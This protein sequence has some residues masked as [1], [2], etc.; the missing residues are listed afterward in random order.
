[1]DKSR[2]PRTLAK[3]D[4]YIKRVNKFI[5]TVNPATLQTHGERLGLTPQEITR[6]GDFLAQWFTGNP[7][8]RGIYEIHTNPNTKTKNSRNTV[9][10][11][12]R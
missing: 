7:A 6:A 4:L 10:K 3:F 1:M 12:M 8:S 5:T 11:I 9:V 2:V